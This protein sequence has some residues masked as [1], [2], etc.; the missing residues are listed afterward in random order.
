MTRSSNRPRLVEM[1]VDA[2]AGSVRL[3][4]VLLLVGAALAAILA[5]ALAVPRHAR[6]Q[7]QSGP[8]QQTMALAIEAAQGM[9]GGGSR[10]PRRPNIVLIFIDTLRAD[11]VGSY[12]YARPTTPRLDRFAAS[13][14]QFDDAHA[15]ASNT[16]R[17]FASIIT[18]RWPSRVAWRKRFA[19]FSDASEDNQT[20]FEIFHA[21]GYRTEAVSAHFYFNLAR[22]VTAG[23][24]A[25]DNRG[26]LGVRET[27]DEVASP[28]ITARAL[29]HLDELAAGSQPFVLMVHYFSPHSRYIPHPEVA[30][31]GPTQLDLYDGE[32]AFVDHYVAQLLDVL[33]RPPLASSTIV[34]VFS[35][36]GEAFGEHGLSLHGRTLYEEEIRVPLLIRVPGT[37]P[38]RIPERVGL[39]DLLPTLAELSSLQAPAAEGRSLAP[40]LRDQQLPP[41]PL[42]MEQLPYPAYP[43]HLVAVIGATGVKV[44]RNLTS[45]AI[46]AYD[47]H[48]DPAEQH[49]LLQV[50]R[51]AARLERALLDDFVAGDPERERAAGR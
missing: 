37:A 11:H 43:I 39:I 44:I 18:G 28:D 16:P 2:S 45:G 24:D 25:W 23:V 12:G 49:D 31:F 14:V 10:S 4:L 21:A 34:V 48:A 9:G 40:A 19:N 42:Y 41:L 47:L 6:A 29:Q 13:A 35:D 26:A 20:L 51:K 33:D 30:D 1:H 7:R 50:D 17:S 38:R 8:P 5:T 22:G 27:V 32:I 46:E 15:Q 3:R 36:H